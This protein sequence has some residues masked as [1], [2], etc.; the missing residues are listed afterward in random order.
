MKLNQ[1]LP[2]W[3]RTIGG[4]AFFIISSLLI[5]YGGGVISTMA[6]ALT[7]LL[8]ATFT[9]GILPTSKNIKQNFKQLKD[10]TTAS[11]EDTSRS[12]AA[13]YWWWIGLWEVLFAV[14]YLVKHFDA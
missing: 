7:S 12:F 14:L 6:L 13:G 10:T 8:G 2:T 3:L 11:T 4:F 5:I 9:Y 1:Q